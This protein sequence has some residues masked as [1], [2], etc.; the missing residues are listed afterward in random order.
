MNQSKHF[1]DVLVGSIF[2]TGVTLTVSPFYI[3]QTIQEGYI[4]WPGA[5][6]F[7]VLGLGLPSI[8]IMY[9]LGCVLVIID[10]RTSIL[11]YW[12]LLVVAVLA[13]PLLVATYWSYDQLGVFQDS[14]WLVSWFRLETMTRSAISY[15][16]VILGLPL[17][18]AI[19]SRQRLLILLLASCSAGFLAT[20]WF[21]NA[22]FQVL[23]LIFSVGTMIYDA[24]FAY[25]LY[26]I[27]KT[28]HSELHSTL[29]RD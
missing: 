11:H 15:L 10:G 21:M 16:P 3:P 24:I 19:N 12:I 5:V 4:D 23:G 28:T 13:L 27:S 18:Y 6:G 14:S 2:A 8:G 22:E 7:S 25:P 20:F 17:G 26:M 1:E 9:V 29:D